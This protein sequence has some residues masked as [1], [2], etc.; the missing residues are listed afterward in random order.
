MSTDAA[1]AL[2]FQ[3]AGWTYPSADKGVLH[4]HVQSIGKTDCTGLDQATLATSTGAT[5]VY[6]SACGDGGVPGGADPTLSA[7]STTGNGDFLVAPGPIDVTAMHAAVLC[8]VSPFAGWGWASNK[9]DT[10]SATVLA[11]HETVVALQCK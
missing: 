6:E 2:I 4:A 5:P 1:E 7:T 3:S 9:A 10:V 8:D 11:G